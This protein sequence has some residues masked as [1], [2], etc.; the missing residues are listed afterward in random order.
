MVA[1]D[2]IVDNGCHRTAFDPFDYNVQYTLVFVC[3]MRVMCQPI[4]VPATQP[5]TPP[6]GASGNPIEPSAPLAP[7]ECCTGAQC[8]VAP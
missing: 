7:D 5:A 4:I 8:C 3:V 1:P 6:T 2:P